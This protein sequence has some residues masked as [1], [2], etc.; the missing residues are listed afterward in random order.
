[1][2]PD[3]GGP[4][5]PRGGQRWP[6]KQPGVLE[7]FVVVENQTGQQLLLA[8]EVQ[9]QRAGV[10]SSMGGKSAQSHGVVSALRNEFDGRLADCLLGSAH[11]RVLIEIAILSIG[12]GPSGPTAVFDS[13]KALRA[14]AA[15]PAAKPQNQR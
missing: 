5:G 10:H 14:P 11:L 3:E 9:V 12:R 6:G 8:F 1:M 15:G 4:G 7:L 13:G 2:T